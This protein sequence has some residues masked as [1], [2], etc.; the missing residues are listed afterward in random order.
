MSMLNLI[1]HT[2]VYQEAYE[3]GRAEAIAEWIEKGKFQN[4]LQTIALLLKLGLS[5]QEVAARLQLEAETVRKVA[6]NDGW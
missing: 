1:R 6:E 3:E 2:K 4:K 5:V